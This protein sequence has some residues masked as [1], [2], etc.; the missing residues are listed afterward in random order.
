MQ[1]ETNSF[2]DVAIL[3]YQDSYS[4]INDVQNV[5]VSLT[6][7]VG[8][9][10]IR[11]EGNIEQK[12]QVQCNQQFVVLCQWRNKMELRLLRG[13]PTWHSCYAYF[14]FFFLIAFCLWR[15]KD[16]LSNRDSAVSRGA[17]VNMSMVRGHICK[18]QT[19]NSDK[20]MRIRLSLVWILCYFQ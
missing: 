16:V 10:F 17:G 7:R 9:H 3:P 8:T 12:H 4:N 19:F 18:G 5:S 15:L 2:D 13:L 11:V 6:G 14:L 1:Q 20:G